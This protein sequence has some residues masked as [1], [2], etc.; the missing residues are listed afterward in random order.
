MLRHEDLGFRVFSSS[1]LYTFYVEALSDEEK[2]R[3]KSLE[4]F[5]EFEG[6]HQMCLH[7][8]VACSTNSKTREMQDACRSFLE[9]S[10]IPGE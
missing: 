10:E 7:Y 6:W 3:V 2:L 9:H 1:D 5:D 8:F 4:M